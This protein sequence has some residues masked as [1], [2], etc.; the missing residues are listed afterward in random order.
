[1]GAW[2]QSHN[3]HKFSAKR[4]H[5]RA[6]QLGKLERWR[7]HLAHCGA[8]E[9]H[10]LHGKFHDAI[11]PDNEPRNRWDCESRQRV[12]KQWSSCFDQRHSG[13]RLQL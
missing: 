13:Y 3:S 4:W 7:S 2:F 10:D 5:R 11:L 9:Q 8:H 6:L 12:E 1:M